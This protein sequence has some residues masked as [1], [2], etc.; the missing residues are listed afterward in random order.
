LKKGTTKDLRISN[1]N[2]IEY[3]T[4]A[5]SPYGVTYGAWTVKWWRWCFS[6]ERKRNPTTDNSGAFCCEGQERPV[7]FLAGTWV[8]EDR[9][10]PYRKCTIPSN[11]S[12]L[13][14]LINCEENP[15]EYPNL[16]SE[17]DMRKSLSADMGT[18]RKLECLV[19]DKKLPPQ[20]VHS[21]PEFFSIRIH[22]D[23]GLNGRGGD[24]TMTSSGYWVF[25]KPLSVG[26]HRI[27]LEGSYQYGKLYS[28]ANYDLLVEQ[29]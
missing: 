2:K 27:S 22:S 6:I 26:N 5:S 19:D 13:F 28:G 29:A 21:D 7:W 4:S 25:L 20:L 9:N 3:Y 1:N 8:S 10:Y 11:V 14:P 12:I 15:L 24:T 23:M 17:D 18:V 16:K